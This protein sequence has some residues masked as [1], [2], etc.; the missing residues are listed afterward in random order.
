MISPTSLKPTNWKFLPIA[1]GQLYRLPISVMAGM[2]GIGTCYAA[3]PSL[4]VLDYILTAFILACMTAGACAINDYWDIPKDR[5]NHPERP[6]PTGLLTMEQGWYAAVIAFACAF[7]AS[8]PLGT[9]IAGLVGIST[10]LLWNYS[11]LLKYSGILGNVIVATII[12]L[13]VLLGSL[14]AGRPWALLYPMGFLFFYAL[15]RELIWDMHDAEGDR[16]QGI[17][18]VANHWGTP[19][20]FRLTWGLLILLLGSIP[21]ALLYLPMNYPGWFTLFTL[22]M[23]LCCSIPLFRYQR[24]QNEIRYQQLVWWERLGLLCGILGLLGS[25]P[26]VAHHLLSLCF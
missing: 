24:Q 13:L 23:L 10:L 2:A 20:A 7:I 11:H 16:Q 17:I 26:P 22:F 25:A 1:L 4:P 6:L 15:A 3:N 21:I 12:A 9:A 8:V 5:I 14:V 18:T 19:I